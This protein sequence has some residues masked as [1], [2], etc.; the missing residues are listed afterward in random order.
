MV[1]YI[2]FKDV[3]LEFGEQKIL[4]GAGFSIE[5]GERVCLIGRNG[6]GKSTLIN[7][8]SGDITP[9]EG[10]IHIKPYLRISRLQ[11]TLPS[12]LN[13]TVFDYVLSGLSGLKSLIDKYHAMLESK[14]EDMRELQSLQHRIEEGG[15]W[16][17]NNLVDRII[18]ELQLPANKKIS[19]LSGGWQRRAAMGKALI[20][21]PE[22]LLLDEPTNH[23]DLSAIQ[24]LEDKIY[25]FEGSLLFVTHDRAF[26]QRLAT[27]I[28]ELDRGKLRSW[29]GS[30]RKF[31]S[32]KER[33]M[34]EEE[35]QN[36]L[37]DKQMEQEE[38]WIRQGIKARRTR[39]EGRVRS[40]EKMREE[41][42]Q[43]IK[44]QDDVRIHIEQGEISGKKIIEMRN[45][46]FSYG[47]EVVIN[48]LSLKIQRGDRVGLI[49]NNGVGKSTLIRIILGEITP[50]S[51]VVKQGTNLQVACFDQLRKKLDAEKTVAEIVGDGSDFIKIN[52]TERH[53]IG[54]LKGFM[55]SP[56]RSM[57]KVGVLSGGECNR[58]LLAKMFTRPSNLLILDEPTN[59]LDIETLEVL[60]QRLTE[61]KGTLIVVSHDREFLDNVVTSTLVF[62]DDGQIQSNVGGYSDWLKQGR[63]LRKDNEPI[64][65]AEKEALVIEDE[66]KKNSK[67]LSY[68][69]QQELNKLPDKI[70]LLEKEIEKLHEKTRDPSFYDQAFEKI[71]IVL[72]GLAEKEKKLE[73]LTA[74]WAEL[75]QM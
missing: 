49:G 44:P 38:T 61:Y 56:K 3:S 64:R 59:D 17:I 60:E 40:L 32:D 31:L 26:M 72:D 48:K 25:A 66:K 58:I 50:Q 67:K 43:R 10:E 36:A 37:F 22:I 51:G 27:R 21:Q 69:Y 33:L 8:I 47:N 45:V 5:A 6:A 4:T 65:I 63:A 14:S 53:V 18:T 34:E 74:R 46:M 29:P 71:R 13:E 12:E 30:Y 11:Q 20:N 57:T 7:I 52:G 2:H 41:F 70:E 39:N 28:L 54:Y 55:F 35:R 19:E 16:N 9:D 1:S 75:E 73:Q 15:G 42:S 62:E 23:L 24:W 68:N